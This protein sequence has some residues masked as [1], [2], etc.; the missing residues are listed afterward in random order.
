VASGVK[1]GQAVV[2]SP[3]TL[4]EFKLQQPVTVSTVS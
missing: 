1:K 4:L 2:V 3:G